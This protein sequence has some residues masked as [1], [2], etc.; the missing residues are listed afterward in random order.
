[1]LWVLL[2]CHKLVHVIV[3]SQS[4]IKKLLYSFKWFNSERKLWFSSL[5]FFGWVGGG[6]EGKGDIL[7]KTQN[8]NFLTSSKLCCSHL[9]LSTTV[10]RNSFLDYTVFLG[11]TVAFDN[12]GNIS[13]GLHCRFFPLHWWTRW[14]C[15]ISRGS[16]RRKHSALFFRRKQ[17]LHC[18]RGIFL[19][20]NWCHGR[21]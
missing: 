9:V 8:K 17:L 2:K 3:M 6:G 12:F 5:Q 20:C 14:R 11:T 21:Y 7:E 16:I 1:M 13:Y 15:G 18:V 4:I 10:G 19:Y